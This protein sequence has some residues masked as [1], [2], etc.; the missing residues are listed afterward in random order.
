MSRWAR[1][2]GWMLVGAGA[3]LAAEWLAGVYDAHWRP[4]SMGMGG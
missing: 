4:R 3:V 2:A 1:R